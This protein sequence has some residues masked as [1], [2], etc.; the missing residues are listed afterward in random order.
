MASQK[1]FQGNSEGLKVL[2]KV[3]KYT[4]FV[5]SVKNEGSAEEIRVK[6]RERTSSQKACN[7][8]QFR[9]GWFGER[10]EIHGL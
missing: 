10:S 4:T 8:M 7:L 9:Q 2:K 5:I 1:R 3:V 6:S